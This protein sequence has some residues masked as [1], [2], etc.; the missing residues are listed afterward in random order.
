M[1]F[2]TF[3]S[4]HD[5]SPDIDI[6]FVEAADVSRIV[7]VIQYFGTVSHK[8]IILLLSGPICFFSPVVA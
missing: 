1:L 7:I 6:R 5:A 8:T 2:T 4:A 3:G